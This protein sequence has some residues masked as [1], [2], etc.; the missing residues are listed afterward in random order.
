MFELGTVELAIKA[1]SCVKRITIANKRMTR[2]L[3]WY[4]DIRERFEQLC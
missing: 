3:G 1:F 4:L 2:W